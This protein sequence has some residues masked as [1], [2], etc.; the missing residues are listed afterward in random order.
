MTRPAPQGAELV[1]LL[2]ER[3]VASVAVPTVEIV[4]GDAAPLDA[5]IGGLG[6]AAWLVLTSANGAAALV[7]R[8]R[9]TGAA[10]PPATRVAAVGP[11]T[12][13]T[14]ERGGIGVGHVPDT[15]LTTAIAD[16]LGVVAGA[17][18]VL[19]R[20]D[21]ATPDLPDELRARG[22]L[23][24]EVVAYRTRLA[25]PESRDPLR[26]ALRDGLAGITFTSASTV[27]GLRG[28]LGSV[29][30]GVASAIPA[31]CIGPITEAAA[32]HAGFAVAGVATRHTAE[33]L[34]D[35]VARWL[36]VEELS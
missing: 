15:Y 3:G 29:E 7:G 14:L 31:F 28:L 10:L 34:A 24:E 35:V 33:D 9:A 22:A 21:L 27:R 1:R 12:A 36:L 6:G 26:G 16:G 4:Q 32:R 30:R 23:V 11:A 20:A 8:L 5:A 17:R 13:E 25:P 2:D 18:I 19:L